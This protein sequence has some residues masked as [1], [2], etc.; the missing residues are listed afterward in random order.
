MYLLG[1][2]VVLSAALCCSAQVRCKRPERRKEAELVDDAETFAPGTT[3]VFKCR[4]GYSRLGSIKMTCTDVG[5]WVTAS[6]EGQCKLK[7]CGHPGDIDFGTFELTKESEFVFGAVVEYKCDDGYQMLSRQKTRQCTANGWS[8]AVPHCE[9]KRCPPVE[10]ESGVNLLSTSFD[11]DEYSV[12]QV[13][14]FECKNP[15]FKIDGAREIFCTSEGEWSANPPTCKEI[16][17]QKPQI[18]KGVVTNPKN[19]YKE[20]DRISYSCNPGF[21]S[22]R[23]AEATCTGNGWSP[24]P[25]CVEIVCYPDRVINGQVTQPKVMYKE[26]ETIKVQCDRGFQLEGDANLPRTCTKN[27]W[28][29]PMK[30]ISKMCDRPQILYGKLTWGTYYG[31]PKTISSVIEYYCNDGYLPPDK[32]YYRRSMC[33]ENGWIPR[34]QCLRTCSNYYV[35]V[36]NAELLATQNVY[37]SGDKVRF[38]CYRDYKTEDGNEEGEIECLPTGTFTT[39]RCRYKKTCTITALDHGSYQPQKKSFYVGENLRYSCNDGFVSPNQN[40]VENLQCT[41]NGWQHTPKCTEIRCPILKES[42]LISTKQAYKEGDV[43][44]LSCKDGYRLSG[45]AY[46]QCHYNGWFPPLPTCEERNCNLPEITVVSDVKRTP[47]LLTYKV[48]AEAV[49][50]CYN[51]YKLTGESRSRCSEH[52]WDPPI[53]SCTEMTC[54]VT[55]TDILTSGNKREVKYDETLQARCAGPNSYRNY[56]CTESGWRPSLPTCS[57]KDPAPTTSP[58]TVAPIEPEKKDPTTPA[59]STVIVVAPGECPQAPQIKNARIKDLK[60]RYYNGDAIEIKCNPEYKLYGLGL[61]NCQDGKWGS[62]P[63]CVQLQECDQPPTIENGEITKESIEERYFTDAKVI[64]KCNA[65]FHISGSDESLCLNG[66]WTAA[67][68]CAGDDCRKAP[69]IEFAF[70]EGE[71]PSYQHN[72]RVEYKCLDGYKHEGISTAKCL[73]GEWYDLPTCVSTKCESPRPIP[74]GRL[75][76][77]TNAEY[78]PGEKVQYE[79]YWGY[80]LEKNKNEAVCENSRW[81]QTPVCKKIGERCDLPPVVQNGVIRQDRRLIYESGSTVEYV[82]PNYYVMEGKA[83]IKCENGVW[84]DPPVCLEPCTA[85]ERQMKVHNIRLRW[86]S[87]T[88]LYSKHGDTMGFSCLDGYEINDEALLRVTCIRGELKYPKCIKRGSCVLSQTT[89]EQNSIYLNRTSEIESGETVEFKCNEGMV[90]ET[91]LTAT[92]RSNIINYPK[93]I[94]DRKC[95]S[96]PNVPNGKLKSEQQDSYDSGVS[97]EFECNPGYVQIGS[98]NVKCT[99]GEWSEIPKCLKPCTVSEEELNNK[100]IE[101]RSQD[102]LDKSHTHGTE[103]NIKCKLGLRH[104]N[105]ASLR[106]ECIDGRMH[107]PKCF[108]KQTCRLDQDKLDENFLELDPLHNNENYYEEGDIVRFRCKQKY[109]NTSGT[110]R[111]CTK[112]EVT[113]PTCSPRQETSV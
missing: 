103:V 4:P 50:S 77:K 34:P 35:R 85:G 18:S 88:K 43:V 97:V 82:C 3:I 64:Y 55:D 23:N 7:S 79:C 11:D 101:L 12:G 80:A 106:L 6:P 32:E 40:R 33:T 81:V 91:S 75:K 61:I 72:D 71:K 90:P 104:P 69:I 89:M 83:I 38:R 76:T 46:S 30:C 41:S 66:Q 70:I 2:L 73:Q 47:Y 58:T 8:G 31:F 57:K 53:P 105:Q 62:L 20:D 96:T 108:S 39:A 54:T 25:S 13:V 16:F 24:E 100:H 59:P 67:P 21:K 42:K 17:C 109:V 28:S 36:D 37:V 27:G 93:C 48:D 92:C 111:T 84:D 110:E 112:G 86:R 78:L 56:L 52:G 68:V 98:V 87:D 45:S 26:G 44:Q 95:V 19:I 10:M 60:S 9:V 65:G 49:F 5:T 29:P 14:R 15:R 113:Y 99:K 51:G 102:D 63:Q 107:Y 1:F 94:A 22:E 74:N